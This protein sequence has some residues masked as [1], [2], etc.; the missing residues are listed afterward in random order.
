MA[1]K[2]DKDCVFCD[3]QPDCERVQI[4]CDEKLAVKDAV[5]ATL[6]TKL[7]LS[8]NHILKITSDDTIVEKIPFED[9][10]EKPQSSDCKFRRRESRINKD[11]PLVRLCLNP[12][13]PRHSR[14]CRSFRIPTCNYKESNG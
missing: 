14:A 12:Q 13:C 5:I 1:C 4:C 8:F 2:L 10:S 7:D 9:E 11:D 3:Q 6:R